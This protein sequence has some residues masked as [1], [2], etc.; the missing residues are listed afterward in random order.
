V[1]AVALALA[2]TVLAGCGGGEDASP[3]SVASTASTASTPASTARST[4]TADARSKHATQADPCEL[5]SDDDIVAAGGKAGVA[6]ADSFNGAFPGCDHGVV[7]VYM[8]VTP[9]WL[10]RPG[11]EPV[12]GIGEEAY[13]D[14]TYHRLA[15]QAGDERF[16]VVCRVCEGDDLDTLGP[17]A[18]RVITELG[19]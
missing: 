19:G 11:S 10:H 14:P 18:E 4:T 2:G 5:L 15:V 13:Y 9:A 7:A 8:G 3:S 1:P 16:F 12:D 17:L 6:N